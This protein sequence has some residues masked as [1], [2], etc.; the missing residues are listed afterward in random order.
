M[1]STC[2]QHAISMQSTC[3]HHAISRKCA[4]FVTV[5]TPQRKRGR[6]SVLLSTCASASAVRTC[7]TADGPDEGRN[8]PQS[9][10]TPRCELAS[11]Q[12]N[13]P[14]SACTPRCERRAHL[15]QLMVDQSEVRMHE[16]VGHAPDEER[17]QRAI[18]DALS[19]HSACPQRRNR[20]R[21]GHAHDEGR[22]QHALRDAI[23][24]GADRARACCAQAVR[25]HAPRGAKAP[26]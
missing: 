9:A 16:R 17:N 18:R 22:N 1:Q 6:T 2:N 23:V 20:E 11:M 25:K 12:R 3:N 21:I 13:Q 8:Q 4:K 7:R 14:Q 26:S 24:F 10:C 5:S 19:M 15:Q